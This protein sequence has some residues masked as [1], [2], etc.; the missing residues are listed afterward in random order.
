MDNSGKH[1]TLVNKILLRYG[2]TP[3]LRIWKNNTG[4][5]KAGTRFVKFGLK[6]SGDILGITCG[7]KFIAIEVK[8]G[9]GRQSPEQKA[10]QSMVEKFG[11]IYILA[12]D[13]N[14]LDDLINSLALS[15]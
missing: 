13:E 5:V 10:F 15:A 1:E 2:A 7:G 9:T 8:T 4:A 14:A 12:R 3:Y 11:G 6:G